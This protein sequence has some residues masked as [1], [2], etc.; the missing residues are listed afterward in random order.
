MVFI[1]SQ[2]TGLD[3]IVGRASASGPED[4][5]S[6]KTLNGR[7]VTSLLWVRYGGEISS[8]SNRSDFKVVFNWLKYL[9]RQISIDV[10]EQ[11]FN[12]VFQPISAC[13]PRPSITL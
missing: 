11:C 12:V 1:Y 13:D 6:P 9:W 3:S 7:V 5:K 2:Y 4:P 8:Q 10:Y